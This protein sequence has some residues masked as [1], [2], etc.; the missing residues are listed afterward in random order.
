MATAKSDAVGVT[1]VTGVTT[2]SGS[3]PGDPHNNIPRDSD[4]Q[5]IFFILPPGVR[6]TYERRLLHC[7]RG[8]S[9]TN[10]PAFI[11]EALIWTY[12][13]RQ[14]NPR[15]LMKAT[16]TLALGHRTKTHGNRALEQ[17]I[18]WLRFETVRAAK[19]HGLRWLQAG[20]DNGTKL[21]AE[22]KRGNVDAQR[23]E[24]VKDWV[25][26]AERRAQKILERGRV[27]WDEAYELAAE[28]LR[29][30]EAKA[31]PGT[32]GKSYKRVK[33]DLKAGRGALYFLPKVPRK[34]LAEVLGPRE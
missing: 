1:G 26:D 30:S 34:S 4:G 8:W 6:T 2:E 16:V 29:G 27:T 15:W 25:K 18:H 21:I 23:I 9:A 5:P 7:E 32:M 17:H 10:D 24:T 13:H 33:R 22:L 14:P 12:L 31:D 3:T 20:V 11:A 28:G 19:G